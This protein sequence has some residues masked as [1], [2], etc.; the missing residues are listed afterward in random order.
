[1]HHDRT[2]REGVHRRKFNGWAVLACTLAGGLALPAARANGLQ[3]LAS[4]E[5]T[6]GLRLAL[7]QGVRSAIN[8]LGTENGFW[9]NPA[10]RIGLPDGLAKATRA[11]KMLGMGRQVDDLTLQMNRAAEAAVPLSAD[12]LGKA[13]ESLTVE[14]ARAIVQGGETSVTRFFAERTRA[15]L[16]QAFE[17][18][19]DRVLQGHGV[20]ERYNAVTGKLAASGLYK[21]E[22][23]SLQAHVTGRTLDGLFALIGEEERRLRQNP[24]QAGSALLGKVFGGLR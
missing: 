13:V 3:S 10:V 9:G 24:A 15:P 14:D 21:P 23:A 7:G 6:Q 4:S 1:M 12:L 22:G 18:V 11:L 17:P 16:S 20:V 2:E 19:V 8:S 5:I